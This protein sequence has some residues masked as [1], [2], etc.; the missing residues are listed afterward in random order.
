[1]SELDRRIIDDVRESA[2][3]V[4]VIGRS[5]VLKKAGSEYVSCCPFHSEKTPSFTVSPKKQFYHC[6][7]CG[8][9]GDVFDFQHEYQGMP[10]MEAVSMLAR[11]AG[12]ILPEREKLTHEA[13]AKKNHDAD[14]MAVLATAT[15]I[16]HENLRLH[17]HAVSYMKKRGLIRN[18][19]IQFGLGYADTGILKYFPD[20]PTNLLIEA[21]LLTVNAD[22]GDIYDKFR[23]RIM[24]PIHNEHGNVVGFGGRVLG[25][26][27]PKYLNSPEN[28]VFHKRRELF[29][30]HF[31]KKEIRKTRTAVIFEGY[32]DVVTLHQYGEKRAVAALGT[33]VTEDQISKLFRYAD[34]LIFCFDGDN[35]GRA[36]SDRAARIVS[37]VMADGKTALFLT[38]ENGSDPDSY[39]K[40]NGI[41][42][43]CALLE[44]DCIPLSVKLTQILVA[45]RD[46]TLPEVK[47]ALAF[48]STAMLS[49]IKRAMVFRDVFARH[50]ATLIGIPIR[51]FASAE[52]A[53]VSALTKS[54]AGKSFKS[55]P[56][57][58]EIAPRQGSMIFHKHLALYCALGGKSADV[59]DV[60]MDDFAELIAAWFEVAPADPI[61]RLAKAGAIRHGVLNAVIHGALARL[62]SRTN[63]LGLAEQN[64][65]QE[66]IL[67]AILREFE[68]NN[69]ASKTSA[70]FN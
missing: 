12:I 3:I 29:G 45:G 68:R 2:D 48:E 53:P 35:A 58:A 41:D 23:R 19:V 13:Q 55:S 52:P 20:I 38:L 42:A 4:D 57:V 1:M 16:F 18:T 26:E 49:G 17:E 59:P 10:F 46:A 6:F 27:N 24:F 40:A 47:A 66:G 51:G 15:N 63:V 8:A 64:K 30:L 5:V 34:E 9:H 33:S 54:Q 65:E 56:V 32:M 61:E 43:W 25:D 37:Q 62:H 22:N 70:L 50:L 39:V 31:A 67:A 36:A 21:G 11:E 28:T 14:L 60:L 69:R 44:N 7:G